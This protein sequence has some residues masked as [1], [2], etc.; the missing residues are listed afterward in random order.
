MSDEEMAARVARLEAWVE[1]IMRMLATLGLEAL[2][3]EHPST[4]RVHKGN[5]PGITGHIG[6]RPGLVVLAGYLPCG[7]VLLSIATTWS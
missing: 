7:S 5:I 3:I 1:V 2:L 4:A 6:V